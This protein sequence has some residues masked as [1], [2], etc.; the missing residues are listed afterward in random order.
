MFEPKMMLRALTS[1]TVAAKKG[2]A[3]PGRSINEGDVLNASDP[4]VKGREH[5]F[6]PLED[7]LDAVEQATAAPGEKRA[8]RRSQRREGDN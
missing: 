8:V 3:G 5:L 1:F 6:Q 7:Y 4:A 2:V